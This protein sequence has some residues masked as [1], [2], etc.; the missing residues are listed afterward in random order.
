MVDNFITKLN[1]NK[2][3]KKTSGIVEIWAIYNPSIANKFYVPLLG[4]QPLTPCVI[5][6]ISQRYC[7]FGSS[8]ELIK[9]FEFIPTLIIDDVKTHRSFFPFPKDYF[10]HL[11]SKKEKEKILQKASFYENSEIEFFQ[12]MIN[13]EK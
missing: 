8:V 3:F 1:K 7:L 11:L 5:D 6:S 12:T 10:W 13:Y 4:T 2:L 9:R